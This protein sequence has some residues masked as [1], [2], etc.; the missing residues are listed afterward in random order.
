MTTFHIKIVGDW[1]EKLRDIVSEKCKK[2]NEGKVLPTEFRPHMK[3]QISIEGPVG[4]PMID[5][6]A[7]KVFLLVAGGIGTYVMPSFYFVVTDHIIFIGQSIIIKLDPYNIFIFPLI[8]IYRYHSNSKL[9]KP[10][11]A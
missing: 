9:C 2:E 8:I 6:R 4:I 7:Y 5:L 3:I 11:N 10:F 1:T